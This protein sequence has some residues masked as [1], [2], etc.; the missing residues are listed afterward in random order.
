MTKEIK[1]FIFELKLEKQKCKQHSGYGKIK[2]AVYKQRGIDLGLIISRLEK[3]VKRN[4]V[5]YEEFDNEIRL[6]NKASN[7]GR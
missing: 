6:Q 1:E 3:I 4:H 2:N 7:H 5:T